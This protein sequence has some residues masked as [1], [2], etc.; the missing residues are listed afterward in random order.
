[1]QYGMENYKAILSVFFHCI[2]QFC[3]CL[4]Q[5]IM[6]MRFFT[7]PPYKQP[8]ILRTMQKNVIS[9]TSNKSKITHRQLEIELEQPF[10]WDNPSQPVSEETF[11]HSHP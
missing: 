7:P 1:M 9:L 2:G 5:Q 6:K 3:Y 4:Q 10:V 8:A 11:T